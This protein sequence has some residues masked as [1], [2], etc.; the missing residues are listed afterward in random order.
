M[1]ARYSGMIVRI[2]LDIHTNRN[3]YIRCIRSFHLIC[4]QGQIITE[5][6][7][8]QGSMMNK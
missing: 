6:D 1:F 7:Q 2:T 5:I 3:S 4:T 8:V